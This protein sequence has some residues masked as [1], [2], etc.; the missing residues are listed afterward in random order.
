MYVTKR[1]QTVVS[2]E[3][4]AVLQRTA[5]RQKR[6]VSDLIRDAI[7]TTILAEAARQDRR[8]AL[9]DLLSL[10]APVTDWAQMEEESIKGLTS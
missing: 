8:E 7:R 6:T 9:H 2:D 4:W 5:Q 3:E 1:M 10:N